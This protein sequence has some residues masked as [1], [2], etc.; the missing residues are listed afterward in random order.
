VGG[1]SGGVVENGGGA[2]KNPWRRARGKRF[3]ARFCWLLWSEVYPAGHRGP[4]RREIREAYG[5][6]RAGLQGLTK[7]LVLAFVRVRPEA[8]CRTCHFAGIIESSNFARKSMPIMG[9][10]TAARKKSNSKLWLAKETIWRRRPQTG[11]MFRFAPTRCGPVGGAELECGRI[12]IE[13]TE[14]TKKFRLLFE[15]FK[16]IRFFVG[17]VD[18]A[19]TNSGTAT[20]GGAAGWDRTGG[21]GEMLA[22]RRPISFP[23]RSSPSRTCG[24]CCRS[25]RGRNTGCRSGR[26]WLPQRWASGGG[27]TCRPT[28][29]RRASCCGTERGICRHSGE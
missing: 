10:A 24:P 1:P 22:G 25:G 3:P 6:G 29:H 16:K 18:I 13:A 20:E 17:N 9:V 26:P 19:V 28:C 21:G 27:P 14:S 15:S 2:C 5:G 23:G 7:E 11:T 8:A 4:R 12:E